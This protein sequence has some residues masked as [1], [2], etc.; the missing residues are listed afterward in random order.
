MP[1]PKGR[2]PV[3]SLEQNHEMR[4]QRGVALTS[5]NHIPNNAPDDIFKLH[6]EK[7]IRATPLKRSLHNLCYYDIR[8]SAPFSKSE[9]IGFSKD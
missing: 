3:I 5:K 9:F 6:D 4:H 8:A 1:K 7:N 2:S